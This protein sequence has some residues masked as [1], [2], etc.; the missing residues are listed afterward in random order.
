MTLQKCPSLNGQHLRRRFRRNLCSIVPV[1]YPTINQLYPYPASTLGL[2][3]SKGV[4]LGS[5]FNCVLCLV[6][7]LTAY[8][9]SYLPANLLVH[10]IYIQVFNTPTKPK[11]YSI[12]FS[13]FIKMEKNIK[14]N[15]HSTCE[16]NSAFSFGVSKIDEQ[17]HN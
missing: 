2:K 3:D 1:T 5:P 13:D 8:S 9:G 4:G 14:L 6:P 10:I 16:P 12:R 15:I 11:E 7:S 17:M